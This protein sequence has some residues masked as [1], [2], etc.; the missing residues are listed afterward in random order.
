MKVCETAFRTKLTGLFAILVCTA[1]CAS[2]PQVT[3]D[4]NQKIVPEKAKKYEDSNPLPQAMSLADQVAAARSDLAAKLSVDEKDLV[5]LKSDA[6]TWRSSA[7]GCPEAGQHYMQAL[8][9]GVLI[10]FSINSKHYRYH[11]E[12]YKAPFYCANDRAESPISASSEI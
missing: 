10:V 8:V 12:Q 5:L 11:A 2:E 4:P 9:S 6:V 1:A 7:I 3:K